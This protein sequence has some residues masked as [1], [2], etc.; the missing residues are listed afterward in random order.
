MLDP[1]Q[2]ADE[3]LVQPSEPV[4]RHHLA[5]VHVPRELQVHVGRHGV[6]QR[7]RLVREQH[8]GP[9]RIAPRERPGHVLPVVREHAPRARV[10][11]A[12][13]VEQAAAD[14]DALVAQH[15]DAERLQV[16]DPR[17]RPRVVLVIAGDEEHAVA[18]AQV[19]QRLDERRELL[20]R[21]VD[22][23]ARDDDHV[24]RQGVRLA[25]HLLHEVAPDGRPDVHVGELHDA[26]PRRGARQACQRDAHAPHVEP[27]RYV[28]GAADAHQGRSPATVPASKRAR[29]TR[30]SGSFGNTPATRSDG[31]SEV[32][33]DREQEEVQG[34]PEPDVRQPRQRRAD[35]CAAAGASR[36]RPAG[37]SRLG[38]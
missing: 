19:A 33:R 34:E 10:V 21:T 35:A 30:R 6:R 3:R 38:R 7:L 27:A 15:A 5:S 23:I 4:E 8:D 32:R 37:R 9:R 14:L 26:I 28:D 29:A 22:Q 13:E 2:P 16:R 24:G 17:V 36:G 1:V 25:D 18:R 31:A 20:D 11:D 12:C